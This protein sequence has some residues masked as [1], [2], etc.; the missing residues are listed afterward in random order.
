MQKFIEN[1]LNNGPASDDSDD[2]H[3]MRYSSPSTSSKIVDPAPFDVTMDPTINISSLETSDITPDDK[4]LTL[5][6]VKPNDL[7]R[8]V[9]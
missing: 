1:T 3:E 9:F 6:F 8:L 2:C 4:D 5:C 7:E